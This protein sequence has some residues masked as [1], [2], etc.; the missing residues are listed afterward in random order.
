MTSTDSDAPV[1]SFEF[2]S[3]EPLTFLPAR[4]LSG[5]SDYIVAGLFFYLPLSMPVHIAVHQIVNYRSVWVSLAYPESVA[6]LL[7]AVL[8]WLRGRSGGLSD[9]ARS[10]S[11]FRWIAVCACA[12]LLL[13][14]AAALFQG[15]DPPFAIRKLTMEWALPILLAVSLR[16][17][18]SPRLD[19]LIRWSLIRGT[20]ALLLVALSTY[21]WSFHI[22]RSFYEVVYVNRTFLIWRGVKEGILFGEIPFGGINPLAAHV[23]TVSCLVIGSLLARERPRSNPFLLVW[24]GLAWLVEFLCFSRGAL[25]FLFAAVIALV[26][27]RRMLLLRRRQSA[28]ILGLTA[29]LF[30]AATVPAGALAYWSQQFSFL[31]GSSAASR[32]SQWKHLAEGKEVAGSEIPAAAS[33][34][35]RK[36][37]SGAMAAEGSKNTTPASRERN[38]NAYRRLQ[39]AI[40]AR[41]G[42]PARRLL[43]GYGLGHYGIL[44]GLVPDS[45]SHNIFVD[46]LLEAGV[47]GAASF[48]LFFALGFVRRIRGVL[49]ARKGTASKYATELARLLAFA[50]IAI[51]G[52]LVDYRLENLGTMTGAGVL[53][54]LLVSPAEGA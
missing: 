20:F 37:V 34:R 46:A 10:D 36:D 6:I 19:G 54:Y 33:E 1:E 50:S 16:R 42:G 39:Q 12:Y 32:S 11:G 31:P 22:P 52:V 28:A 25:L 27:N 47:L 30:L 41:I 48:A 8:V 5:L 26:I 24:I 18:W 9:S 23:S 15:S 21:V 2:P 17:I 44:R 35:M 29:A 3:V 14:A 7:L 13:A 38:A 51:I 43:V 40:S 49:A 53:W 45:G 4:S